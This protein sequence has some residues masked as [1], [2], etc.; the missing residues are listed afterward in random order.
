MIFNK[1]EFIILKKTIFLKI[2]KFGLQTYF[3]MENNFKG[4]ISVL[5]LEMKDT[6]RSTKIFCTSRL[7]V[8]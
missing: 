8:A 4:Q 1:N 5:N 7:T 2:I 6:T 3:I